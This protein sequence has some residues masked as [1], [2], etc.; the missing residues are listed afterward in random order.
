M[1]FVKLYLGVTYNS[2]G[3]F[4]VCLFSVLFASIYIVG[5]GDQVHPPSPARLAEFENAGPL[6]LTVDEQKLLKA[7]IG[8]GPYRVIQNEVLEL[9]MPSI[10]KVVTTEESADTATTSPYICR[11]SDNGTITLPVIGE[12][13]V[14]GKTLAEIESTVIKAYYPEYSVTRPSVFARVLEYNTA[15]VSISGAVENP[16]V[17]SLRTDQMSLVALL[18][19]AGGIVE[20]GAALIRINH[21]NDGVVY[22]NQRSSTDTEHSI[23]RISVPI[24]A[25]ISDFVAGNIVFN[26]IEIQL[27]FKLYVSSGRKGTLYVTYDKMILLEEQLDVTRE[28]ERRVLLELLSKKEPWLPIT[29]I[30][31]KLCELSEL[32]ETGSGRQK[33]GINV[34]CLD[35]SNQLQYKYQIKYSN[36]WV[37]YGRSRKQVPRFVKADMN[38]ESDISE[39]NSYSYGIVSAKHGVTGRSNNPVAEFK[40]SFTMQR[41]YR[42]LTTRRV[43]E[44]VAQKQKT[45]IGQVVPASHM[46]NSESIVLPIKGLNIPFADVLLQDGD[47][48]IVERLQVP[49]FTVVGLVNSPGNFEYP[50]D[51]RYNLMQVLAFAKGLNQV[52]EPRYV[53]VYRLKP[54]GEI[55]SV[56]LKLV[57]TGRGPSLTDV[58]NVRIKPGDIISVEHTPRTRTN[59]FLDRI[60][61]INIG[62]YFSLNDTWDDN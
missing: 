41:D 33:S 47:N 30:D 48:V 60:F 44:P 10:L 39:L 29:H 19:E 25:D 27:D 49:L 6:Q 58:L 9:T 22:S 7:K 59:L 3:L 5:C 53:T 11:I 51:A 38:Y 23:R 61:R 50:P 15:K 1:N 37:Y 28:I 57:D 18:M 12:I 31:Q 16:G 42:D 62:T 20:E 45:S 43:L 56:I 52:A 13:E 2:K 8:G 46:R 34:T 24:E 4:V 21:S 32:L 40:T 55:V 54:D 35:N 17:Y 36:D 14:A 26:D